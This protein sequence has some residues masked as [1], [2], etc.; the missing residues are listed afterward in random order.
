MS[1]RYPRI[2]IITV[3]YNAASTI[4]STIRSIALQ[5][6]DDYEYII[7][8]GGSTDETLNI[9]K[10]NE[11][12]IECFISEK[13]QGIYDAMN[14]G[15]QKAKGKYVYFIGA[16]DWLCHEKVIETINRQLEMNDEIDILCSR[17]AMIDEK[18]KYQ[19][20]VGKALTKEEVYA[21]T[22]SPHQG[23]FAKRELL[24]QYPFNIKYKLAADYE[25]L[26]LAYKSRLNI[27]YIEDIVAYYN[28]G[29]LSTKSENSTLQEYFNIQKHNLA[30]K[31]VSYFKMTFR[32]HIMIR[33]RQLLLKIINFFNLQETYRKCRKWELHSC[34]KP[35]CR[36]CKT[37][38]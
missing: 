4:E 37:H 9:I 35:W 12:H 29:G 18:T 23:M 6:S 26:L 38:N 27:K 13:D 33:T 31:D 14:K 20:I 32:R 1:S 15:V 19:I 25:F 16:D 28:A 11:K 5:E 3:C 21:G 8:D 30:R 34:G 36:C 2:S 17:V 7:I 24:L 10:Q 22:M